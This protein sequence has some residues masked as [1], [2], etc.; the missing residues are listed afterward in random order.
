MDETAQNPTQEQTNGEHKSSEELQGQGQGNSEKTSLFDDIDE[1]QGKQP[2][3]SK[4]DP[5]E[6]QPLRAED[7]KLPDGYEYDKALG[8]SFLGILNGAGI[9]KETAQKLFDLYQSQN[10][11]LLEGLK[12]AETERVKKFEADMATEKAEWLKQCEADKEYGGHNWEASQVVIGVLTVRSK[13][14]RPITSI[15]ILRL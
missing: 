5:N 12:A 4:D 8:D 6:Q 14:C 15:L 2:E 11:K 7:I 3:Q 10:I 9:T 13:S 1:T